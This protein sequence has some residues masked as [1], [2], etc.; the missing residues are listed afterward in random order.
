MSEAP[1]AISLH[2]RFPLHFVRRRA[3]PNFSCARLSHVFTLQAHQQ[4]CEVHMMEA[5]I[6]LQGRLAPVYSW[7]QERN[8]FASTEWLSSSFCRCHGGPTPSTSSGYTASTPRAC[9]PPR[10]PP[11]AKSASTRP[12]GAARGARQAWFQLD[13]LNVLFWLLLLLT[14]GTADQVCTVQVSLPLER[15]RERESEMVTSVHRE[16]SLIL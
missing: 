2:F 13:Q 6:F 15:E 8:Q 1:P 9:S 11:W 3:T 4:Q 5:C 16:S 7:V 12:A 10:T 14:L